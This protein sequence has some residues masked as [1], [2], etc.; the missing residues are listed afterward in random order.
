VR[1]VLD[2]HHHSDHSY[3]NR[4][5]ADA[6]ATII[7]HT[8]VIDEMNAGEPAGWEWSARTRE[9]VR[10]TTLERPSLLFAKDLVLDDGVRRVELH[11]FGFG[12][13]KGDTFVWLPKEKI[14]FTGDACVNGAF[15]YFG[16]A[17]VA[18]WIKALEAAKQLG[19]TTVCPGHGLIGGPELL[20][21]QQ[22]Y[23]VELMTRVKALRAANKT[24]AEAKAA[25]PVMIDE[26]KKIANIA[27]YVS[28]GLEGHA[29]RVW[30][31]LGGAPFPK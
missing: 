20:V 26:L 5:W 4:L 9:D 31:E 18:E 10:A 13:T 23:F 24:P 27:R 15:N 19:A 30:T 1:L 21:D 17:H 25:V 22:Q 3:G 16:N 12:H 28:G 14:L 8:G 11:W 2:T 7:A 29:E 6:G